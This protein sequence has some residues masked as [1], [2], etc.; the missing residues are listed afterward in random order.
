MQN[1]Q[2]LRTWAEIDLAALRHNYACVQRLAA[3]AAVMPVIKANAYG[4]GAA[5]VAAAL[6]DAPMLAVATAEEALHLR[7]SGILQPLLVLGM[8]P[9]ACVAQLAAANVAVNCGSL[10][11]AQGYA[12]AMQPV[13][14]V[15]KLGVHLKVDTGMART[16]FTPAQLLAALP[17]LAA[18][19]ALQV[20]GVFSHFAASDEAAGD[21]YSASQLAAFTAVLA[22]VKQVWPQLCVHMA[23][24]GGIMRHPNALFDMVRPGIMLYG[25]AP[26]P[27]CEGLAGLQ[28]VLSWRARVLQVRTVAAG[29]SVGYGMAWQ[30]ARASRIAVVAA[31]YAD[32]L[33]RA[34]SGKHKMLV[35]G[36]TAPQVGRVCMDMCMLDVTDIPAVQAGDTATLI[37]TDG[38]AQITAAQVGQACGTIPYEVLC[39]LSPRVTR[40]YRNA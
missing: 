26:S 39:A 37:G 10:Q 30:A 36:Q 8:V 38:A 23:N 22:P 21:A 20:Q 13:A 2:N 3:P 9:P 28:P 29:E 27:Q 1:T 4:H 17:Q 11:T 6:P 12:A 25:C 19:P 33:H 35:C 31:G 7:A 16:G 18:L 32:G 15:Y 34:G 24:S 5:E 40:L 14:H